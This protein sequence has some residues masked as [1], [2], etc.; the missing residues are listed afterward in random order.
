L[1][2]YGLD[3]EEYLGKATEWLNNYNAALA[4]LNT[5]IDGLLTTGTNTGDGLIYSSE[6]QNRIDQALSSVIPDTTTTGLTANNP[7][8]DTI[9]NNGTNQTI[10]IS[11]IELPN[12]ENVDDFVD[13]LKDLPRL[14]TANSALRT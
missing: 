1:A 2:K 9:G 13:A 10:Y 8:Y 4:E 6:I 5:T 3:S 11:N 14:A 12:V 7:N